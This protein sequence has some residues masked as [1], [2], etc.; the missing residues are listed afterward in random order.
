[1]KSQVFRIIAWGLA[2]GVSVLWFLQA[3]ALSESKDELDALIV[4]V[5]QKQGKI[6]LVENALKEV[7][8]NLLQ[9]CQKLEEETETV[10]EEISKIEGEVNALTQSISDENSTLA[11]LTEESKSLP[12]ELTKVR[13]AHAAAQR[14]LPPLQES[15]NVIKETKSSLDKQLAEITAANDR[16]QAE[17]N[18]LRDNREAIR[19]KYEERSAELRKSIEKPPWLYYGDKTRVK[20]MNVRPSMTGA[21]LPLGFGDGVKR[22][23]EFLVRRIDSS[24]PTKR[25]WRVKLKIVQS[26]YCFA[27]ILP[28]YGDQNIS[29]RSGEEVEL[30]RSG[31]LVFEE[32]ENDEKATAETP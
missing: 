27:V 29:L 4:Q 1:L 9:E 20:V 10:K 13:A 25:S 18:G 3:G 2:L 22:G 19:L 17:L 31:N 11:L 30:E 32:T 12:E 7:K 6:T 8:V 14:K 28:E 21:F 26:N 24:S 5:K 16:L 15:E 23:M